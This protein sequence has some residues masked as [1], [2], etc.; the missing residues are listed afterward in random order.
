MDGLGIFKYLFRYLKSP[1]V[2]ICVFGR[3]LKYFSVWVI[4]LSKLDTQMNVSQTISPCI[5]MS[6]HYQKAVLVFWELNWVVGDLLW[7]WAAVQLY[8]F[9]SRLTQR[10][11]SLSMTN[12]NDSE[13]VRDTIPY[14]DVRF[15]LILSPFFASP[16]IHVYLCVVV[17]PTFI[18]ASWHCLYQHKVD[19]RG[20]IACN[21]ES[22]KTVLL[23]LP[24]LS[25]WLYISPCIHTL[26]LTHHSSLIFLRA[27]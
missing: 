19:V 23:L 12:E 22:K 8:S 5:F 27:W 3:C 13:R 14:V 15:R 11:Y 25:A 17:C 24:P 4:F 16:P 20:K 2:V 10:R 21:K 1:V 18:Q 7:V 26:L 6:T 9:A